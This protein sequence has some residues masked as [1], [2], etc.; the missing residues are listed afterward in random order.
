MM[1][2]W[3]S[4]YWF[5]YGSIA[6]LIMAVAVAVAS[7]LGGYLTAD[8]RFVPAF[9][10]GAGICG[11]VAGYNIVRRRHAVGRFHRVFGFMPHLPGEETFRHL[12]EKQIRDR[13]ADL[14]SLYAARDQARSAMKEAGDPQQA[15]ERQQAFRRVSGDAAFHRSRFYRTINAA[16]SLWLP[17]PHKDI[18]G[19]YLDWENRNRS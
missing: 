3:F 2:R 17:A 11:L 9:Y 12:V 4:R 1:R 15:R 5:T 8:H 6:F 16:R 10:L 13:A 14:Q 18:S 19:N 7:T